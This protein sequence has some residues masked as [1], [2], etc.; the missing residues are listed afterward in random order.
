MQPN[1]ISLEYESKVGS[2]QRITLK[3]PK[4]LNL[5][6]FYRTIH[7]EDGTIIHKPLVLTSPENV[8]VLMQ[9]PDKI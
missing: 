5:H 2:R 9:S 6:T 3:K 1:K 4:N 8:N 7:L